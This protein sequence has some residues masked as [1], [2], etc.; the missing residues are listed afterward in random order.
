[1]IEMIQTMKNTNIT[2]F[3]TKLLLILRIY[4]IDEQTSKY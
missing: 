2:T 3:Y 1:M 4:V